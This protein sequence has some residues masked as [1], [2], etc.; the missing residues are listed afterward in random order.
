MTGIIRPFNGVHPKIH[1]TAFVADTAVVIG[2]VEIGPEASI[3]YGCIVRGDLN[4]IRI[5]A[6]TNIQ[7]GTII[8]VDSA[9]EHWD[10]IP[11]II[12]E[13]V[14]VGHQALLHACTLEDGAFVG[15]GATVMDDCVVEGGAMVAAGALVTPKKRVLKG[16]LWA[17]SPARCLRPLKDEEIAYFKFV[18]DTYVALGAEHEADQ[19]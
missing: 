17:G 13:R 6:R 1:E 8:H 9:G 5:G 10:G 16:E 18:E 11:T 3:W 14:N 15:M 4:H 7:D 12:G 2:D 19:S